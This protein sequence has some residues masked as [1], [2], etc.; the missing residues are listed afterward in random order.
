MEAG[1]PRRSEPDGPQLAAV[2]ERLRVLRLLHWTRVRVISPKPQACPSRRRSW[3]NGRSVTPAMGARSGGFNCTG[4]S[5]WPGYGHPTAGG[6]GSQRAGLRQG[7]V[8]APRTVC[9]DQASIGQASHRPGT[10]S[11]RSVRREQG[12]ALIR[13][14]PAPARSLCRAAQLTRTRRQQRLRSDRV[15]G[16]RGLQDLNGSRE[17]WQRDAAARKGQIC[18]RAVCTLG[19]A[20]ARVST[21]RPGRPGEGRD[22][23]PGPRPPATPP[24]VVVPQ[25]SGG[26]RSGS[27]LARGGPGDGV[28]LRFPPAGRAR[29]SARQRH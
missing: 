17:A 9:W 8:R 19:N 3:R 24:A 1:Q 22:R 12:A 27:R 26:L 2:V 25:R 6:R 11:G 13:R 5:A 4:R 23:T 10:L 7:D 14:A 21:R 28:G 18:A 29:R 16:K 15:C 20:T